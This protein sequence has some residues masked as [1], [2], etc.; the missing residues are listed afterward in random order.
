MPLVTALMELATLAGS[1]VVT[2]AT[3]DA[4]ESAR[5]GFARLLGRGEAEKTMLAERRLAEAH[6]QLASAEA[7][8]LDGIR[9]RCAR[10]GQPGWL[11][12]WKR[13]RAWKLTCAPWCSRSRTSCLPRWCPQRTTQSRSGGM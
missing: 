7:A 8:D 11:T 2:A 1:T 12:C 10:N 13:P 4:W 5:R 9:E 3:T 6:D